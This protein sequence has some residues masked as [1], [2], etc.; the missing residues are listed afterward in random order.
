MHAFLRRPVSAGN[1]FNQ[2]GLT[3]T[4]NN[5]LT[6]TMYVDV[7]YH[8]GFTAHDHNNVLPGQ[9]PQYRHISTTVCCSIVYQSPYSSLYEFHNSE[10]I[11]LTNRAHTHA[12]IQLLHRQR[13]L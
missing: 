7:F 1:T 13:I 12:R 6:R 2:H 4:G 8:T 9:Q 5:V 10:S 11:N 3:Q